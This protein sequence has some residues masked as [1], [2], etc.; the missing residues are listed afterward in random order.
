MARLLFS[1]SVEQ[2]ASTRVSRGC[3]PHGRAHREL[4]I[5]TDAGYDSTPGRGCQDRARAKFPLL[6][7][8]VFGA[9]IAQIV[10]AL[11]IPGSVGVN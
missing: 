3:Q 8:V 7:F 10:E 9:P 4:L 6:V 5:D 2:A 1:C 11:D